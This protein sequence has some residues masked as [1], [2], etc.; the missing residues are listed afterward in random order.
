MI[1][2][3]K[4]DLIA[5]SF[6][7]FI[8]ESIDDNAET[9]LTIEL[10]NIEIIKGYIGSRYDVE[11][12]FSPLTP[13]RNSILIRILSKLTL[14]DIINRN[15]PRKVSSDLKEE[16][17]KAIEMLD[18]IATGRI[19]IE[20]LPKPMDENGNIISDSIWGNN[21]NKDFYL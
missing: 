17:D 15:A 18:K 4:T 14:F 11:E 10:Q 12:I 8:D 1:Y 6:E 19:K 7:K 3:K 16:Y 20:G 21:S 13:V 5:L 2:L 9:L